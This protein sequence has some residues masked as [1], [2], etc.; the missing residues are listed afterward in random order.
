M[1]IVLAMINNYSFLVLYY[2]ITYLLFII[3]TFGQS[4]NF[5]QLKIAFLCLGKSKK[6]RASHPGCCLVQTTTRNFPLTA[7]RMVLDDKDVVLQYVAYSRTYCRQVFMHA[8]RPR[9]VLQTG[10]LSQVLL[11]LRTWIFTAT[12]NWRI[13]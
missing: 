7:K 9:T 4:L 10:L 6:A 8:E 11:S 5:Q 12:Q 13:F 3:I 2:S 1:Y